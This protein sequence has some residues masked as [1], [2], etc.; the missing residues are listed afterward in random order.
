MSLHIYIMLAHGSEAMATHKVI[1]FP[2]LCNGHF[3][4]V[5]V[6]L[7]STVLIQVPSYDTVVAS[8]APLPHLLRTLISLIGVPLLI[9]TPYFY[10]LNVCVLLKFIY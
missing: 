8:I 7:T 2:T 10:E 1:L 6:F 3:S 5:S 4:S 9:V